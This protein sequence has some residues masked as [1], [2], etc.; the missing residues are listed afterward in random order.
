[1]IIDQLFTQQLFEAA[2]PSRLIVS[3]T[4]QPMSSGG[5]P[6]QKEIDLTGQFQGSTA[7]QMNQAM[8][9][10]SKMLESKGLVFNDLSVSY[11]GHTIN[12]QNRGAMAPQSDWEKEAE[13]KAA[14]MRAQRRAATPTM[15]EDAAMASPEQLAYNR[16]RAQYDSYQTMTGGGGNTAVSR[17]P[18]HAAKLATVPAELARMAA[19]LK[20]K[21][22]DAE[23]EYDAIGGPKTAPVD[24]NQAYGGVDERIGDLRKFSHKKNKFRS[25]DKLRNPLGEEDAI[26][27]SRRGFLKKAAGAAAAGAAMSAAGPEIATLVKGFAEQ[28]GGMNGIQAL[29]AMLKIATADE[30][31]NMYDYQAD[32]GILA[33]AITDSDM[34]ALQRVKGFRD[35]EDWSDFEEYCEDNNDVNPVEEFERLTGR[36]LKVSLVNDILEK[37][38]DT[39]SLEDF[40]DE[41][42]DALKLINPFENGSIS[43]PVMQQLAHIDKDAKGAS[44]PTPIVTM[45]N[46]VAGLVRQIFKVNGQPLAAPQ[47]VSQT[48]P[49]APALPAPARPEFDIAPNVKHKERVPVP[50]QGADD[51]E[52]PEDPEERIQRFINAGLNRKYGPQKPGSSQIGNQD[53]AE[54]KGLAKKVRQT[55]NAWMEKDQ[56]YENPTKRAGFQAKVW[57]YIEQNIKTIL[58]DRGEDGKGSYPA[59]PYAAWLLVQ[60]MDADPQNQGKFLQQLEQSGLDPTDGN[61]GEGKLQFLKDRYKVNKWIAANSN[62]KEYFINNEPLPNPT[63]NVRNPYMFKDAGQ[64]ATSREDALKNAVAAGNKL[65]VAAVQATDAQTQPSYKSNVAESNTLMKKL[66]QALLQEGRV[67]EL[68][69]DL[70]TM[71]DADFMKKYGKAK[72]A[73]RKEMNRV[74]EK[75]STSD[76]LSRPAAGAY[77]SG[78]AIDDPDIMGSL[79]SA[80]TPKFDRFSKT[81]GEPELDFRAGLGNDET[82]IDTDS[83]LAAEP[84]PFM[85]SWGGKYATGGSGEPQWRY[86]EK[87]EDPARYGSDTTVSGTGSPDWRS[88]AASGKSAAAPIALD[89]TPKNKY[90][91]DRITQRQVPADGTGAN[92]NIDDATRDRARAW[93]AQ[94]NAPGAALAGAMRSS[95][96]PVDTA[97]SKTDWRTIYNLNKSIIGNDPNRIRPGMKL[98]MPDGSTYSVQSGDTLSKIAGNQ[99]NEQSAL[100][101]DQAARLSSYLQKGADGSQYYNLPTTNPGETGATMGQT[102]ISPA[103]LAQIKSPQG[104]QGIIKQLLA[105]TAPKNA[106]PQTTTTAT[107]VSGQYSGGLE[108]LSTNQLARYKTAAAKDAQEADK[109]G[110]FKR[111]DK[112]FHGM[113]QATKKQFDND[114]KKV[115]ENRAARRALMARIVNH[116]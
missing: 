53:M 44:L 29:K 92:P 107:D 102:N 28:A 41:Y 109:E 15:K 7:S 83:R 21:G 77:S 73:I 105:M 70:K 97:T 11:Q 38:D 18:V 69:D 116:R 71:S 101:P 19:A 115:D 1:M 74:D 20:A 78:K 17:D 93:A 99:I 4:I 90:K 114:A 52:E 104:Q 55:L 12:G 59:A 89:Q 40:F 39:W 24:A 16:L 43:R 65:L 87:G 37:V 42:P 36:S 88:I 91:F 56:Q 48:S 110:D 47:Q 111:G 2:D 30:L 95:G 57:P 13:A 63:V 85:Q 25:L 113:V 96:N 22:I 68:A 86:V 94:Q 64:V 5:E 58:A 26:D 3:I 76:T 61:D 81:G 82:E 108:E 98:K 66:H 9:Y 62:N 33:D 46:A 112:R 67:K 50:R 32:S 27:P 80:S 14:Q 60:H 79:K 10:M 84:N 49:A 34:R 54:G 51:N 31:Y 103:A 100:P 106:V 23:A 8:D 35:Y 6:M 75:L 45:A 72:A